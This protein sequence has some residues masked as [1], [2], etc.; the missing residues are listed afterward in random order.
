M[1]AR[2]SA[3]GTRLL[4]FTLALGLTLAAAMALEAQEGP[5]SGDVELGDV[6]L[7]FLD[8][9]GD[10]L[11]VVLLHSKPWDAWTYDGFGQRLTRHHR[12]LA[13]TLRGSGDS[14]GRPADVATD[15]EDILGFMDALEIDRAVLVG[16]S[17]PGLAMTYLAEHH[18][19][20][21]AGLVYLAPGIP[22]DQELS[23]EEGATIWEM[24]L[25]AQGENYFRNLPQ[26]TYR[27]DYLRTEEPTMPVRALIFRNRDG[28]SAIELLDVPTMLL[29]GV[30]PIEDPDAEAYF[31]EA[32]E[33]P[34]VPARIAR[35]WEALLA[36]ESSGFRRLDAAFSPPPRVVR[37]D[38]DMVGGYE[39][40]ESPDLILPQLAGFLDEIRRAEGRLEEERDGL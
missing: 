20:R 30:I 9:G 39:Y 1:D 37:L 13:P 25:R 21:I 27:P 35:L 18:P 3:R 4:P 33:D 22:L 38:V 24:T 29:D 16:N 36:G 7:H 5:S 11:P 8:F 40:R 15:G 2:R 23:E 32:R 14:G 17:T 19:D 34:E 31:R 6:R 26:R 28:R 12:V 10:G